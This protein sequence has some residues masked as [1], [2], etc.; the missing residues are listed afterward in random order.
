MKS[1]GQ[2]PSQQ[3]ARTLSHDNLDGLLGSFFQAQ[4]PKAWPEAGSVTE[5]SSD[6]A[7]GLRR[8]LTKARQRLLLA[9]CLGFLLLG[10]LFLAGMF[11]GL[12]TGRSDRDGGKMEA[13][14]RIGE[15]RL[16]R[17]MPSSR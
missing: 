13:T 7:R 15:M 16:K 12:P 14:K 3:T 17:T 9:A 1:L 2:W 8:S 10:Q 6:A 5:L 4:M 11:T